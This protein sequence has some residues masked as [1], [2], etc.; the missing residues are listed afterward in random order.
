MV[1]RCGAVLSCQQFCTTI[2]DSGYLESGIQSTLSNVDANI[3]RPMFMIR[4][5]RRFRRNKC[6]LKQSSVRVLSFA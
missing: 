2:V 3:P 4:S 5:A 6:I 1:Q